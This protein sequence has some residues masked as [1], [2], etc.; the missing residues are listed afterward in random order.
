L[1]DA[2]QENRLL[3]EIDLYSAP[4]RVH[5]GAVYLHQGETYLVTQLDLD[6]RYAV[7]R[8]AEVDYYTQPR[9]V[10]DVAIV[11]SLRH[12]PL[13]AVTAFYGRLRAVEQVIGYRRLQQFSE[14]VLGDE[15][16]DLPPQSFETAA[17]WFDLPP[18]WGHALAAQG[19]DF[20]GGLHALEH[21][22]IAMLPLFAMCDRA[23]IGGLSTPLHPDTELPQV[24]IYDGFPGG[25]GIAEKGFDLLP[26]LWRETLRLVDECPCEAGCPSCVQ[27]PKCGNNNQPLDKAAAGQLLRWLLHE[28]ESAGG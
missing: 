13:G 15:P 24:F 20:H 9:Q 22:L 25:I 27:S 10:N 23:D 26:A 2:S 6:M 5:E 7:L 12:R 16:L 14:T 8:P 28:W 17:L 3:E 11:R 4:A 18:E 19:L 1:L 21:A